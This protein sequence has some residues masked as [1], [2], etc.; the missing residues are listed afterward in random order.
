MTTLPVLAGL[1]PLNVT[2]FAGLIPT[3]VLCIYYLQWAYVILGVSKYVVGV[4]P[5]TCNAYG[6]DCTAVF[7]PGAIETARLQTGNLNSTLLNGT[8][9]QEESTI[10]IN[11]APGYQLEFF[12]LNYY[13]FDPSECTIY[14]QEQNDGLQICV[15]SR[16]STIVAGSTKYDT[17]T[18][19]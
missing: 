18:L 5:S 11:N 6:S 19:M 4:P 10:L 12:P 9:F 3:S 14:G 13:V 2:A 1:T 8:I 7:L 16:G 17:F 15:S